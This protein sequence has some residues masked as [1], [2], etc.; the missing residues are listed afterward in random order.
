MKTKVAALDFVC[1][2]LIHLDLDMA[3]LETGIELFPVLLDLLCDT[4]Q[5]VVELNLQVLSQISIKEDYFDKVLINL[6][7][8]FKN[9][10][11]LLPVRGKFIIEKLCQ[12][13]GS[14]RIYVSIAEKLLLTDEMKQDLSFCSLM[15]QS[16]NIIL[17]TTD[18]RSMQT[19]RNNIGQCQ[20]DGEC[21]KLFVS[22]FQ[23]W[24]YN[25]VATLSLCLM[26]RVYPLGAQLVLYFANVDITIG[27]LMQVDKLVS[28]IESPTFVHL[29]LELL[30][31]HKH[32]YLLK[33]MY[34]LLM[35]LP[36][37]N[38]F[39]SL[40]IR[41]QSATSFGLLDCIPDNSERKEDSNVSS[42][43]TGKGAKGKFDMNTESLF[44]QFVNVQESFR[45]QRLRDMK[46]ASFLKESANALGNN[47][48]RGVNNDNTDAT[49]V[50]A[51]GRAGDM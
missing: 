40:R 8:V 14:Q 47:E 25:P 35:L 51:N 16:L 3:E 21:W 39:N 49:V 27:F 33:I 17:L 13:L 12:L 44:D 6:L 24:C 46:E 11:N 15:V 19:L 1:M 30:E 37:N 32:P 38:A 28:L 18:S 42:N 50:S 9:T 48:N 4:D 43:K 7:R 36:Q 29:R 20:S 10:T 26:G 23:T 22:L 45:K 41:L 5:H 31:P 34:G 2:M